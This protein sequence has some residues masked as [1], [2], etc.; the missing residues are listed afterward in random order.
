MKNFEVD[1]VSI[2]FDPKWKNIA[3]SLSGGADSALLTFLICNQIK[4]FSTKIH[5]INHV[6]C[7]KT[8][9][10]QQYDA[11]SV[12]A[13]ISK[14]FPDIS[15]YKHIN[16]ISP[17][18][19]YANIGPSLID[20]YGKQVS[21]DNIEQRAY[22]EFVCY[23]NQVDAY[24]NAVTRNPRSEKF[25]GMKERDI[26]KNSENEHLEIMLHMGKWALHPFR[27]V[28][29]FWIIKQYHN[30]NLQDLLSLTRSCEGIFEDLDYRN[31]IP[32]QMVPICNECFWCKERKWAVEQNSTFLR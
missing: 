1:G 2:P 17:E 16:F 10:W 32:G 12:I 14:R 20:E 22:A 3:I 6:R 28:E 29:K 8:K 4:D 9:P 23:K 19:E 25:N 18:L 26:E 13:W 11:E 24:Y 31:Y 27:F 21:G 7:W 5:I 30:F 15:F